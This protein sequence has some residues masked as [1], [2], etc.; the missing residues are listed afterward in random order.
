[1]DDHYFKNTSVHVEMAFI[2]TFLISQCNE[3]NFKEKSIKNEMYL[4]V[5]KKKHYLRTK[6][7]IKI[8]TE[9]YLFKSILKMYQDFIM[10]SVKGL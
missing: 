6:N 1:M 5:T 3:S 8:K 4:Q 7:N 10:T 2:S 9:K